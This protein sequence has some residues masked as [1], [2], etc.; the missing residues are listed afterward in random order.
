MGSNSH[1]Q[2]A[3]NAEKNVLFPAATIEMK[4]SSSH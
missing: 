2:K 3:E 1:G 4:I